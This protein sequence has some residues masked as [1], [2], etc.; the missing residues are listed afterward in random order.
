MVSVMFEL[1]MVLLFGVKWVYSHFP[2]ER[3]AEM[4]LRQ[5]CSSTSYS[6]CYFPMFV[7]VSVEA[8]GLNSQPLF[9]VL[10]SVT[11]AASLFC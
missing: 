11:E 4:E 2:P 5:T 9:C 7:S 10:V 1:F 3:C 6:M 8:V